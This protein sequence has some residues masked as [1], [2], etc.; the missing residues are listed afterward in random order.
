MINYV[1][2]GDINKKKWD[3][4]IQNSFNRLPFALSWYLDR[5]S[6]GW[7]ALIFDDYLELMPLTLRKKY[8]IP[9]LF[10]PTLCPRLGVFSTIK[11]DKFSVNDYL[12]AI[13]HK[14][15]L[16]EISLNEYNTIQDLLPNS[17]YKLRIYQEIP[18]GNC[19]KG[20]IDNYSKSHKRNI[21][22]FEN[23][24]NYKLCYDYSTLD[25]FKLKLQ[26]YNKAKNW[27]KKN[28]R[29]YFSLL[30]EMDK[31]DKL[32][33]LIITENKDKI[34][35]GVAILKYDFN[36]FGFQSFC[37]HDGKRKSTG[38]FVIHKFLDRYI[39]QDRII[40]FMGSELKG[41]RQ[42]NHGFKGIDREYYFVKINRLN[43]LIRF[44]K[45]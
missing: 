24:V 35:G 13:P 7:D 42:R 15:R 3:L 11:K 28:K 19:I 16:I 22:K 34:L 6:P 30:E 8:G 32:E 38:I 9:Y 41:I 20:L 17:N 4:A 10:Q 37:T 27:N 21:K 31:R 45:N 26:S 5:V 1:R 33:L 43:S 40:D 25:F 36:R 18:R 29:V 2:H 44:M 23:Q 12:K 14:F 39:R